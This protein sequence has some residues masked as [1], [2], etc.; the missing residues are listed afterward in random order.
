MGEEENIWVL[1]EKR[2]L[3][4]CSNQFNYF[5]RVFIYITV[6]VT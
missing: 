5:V 4:P 3:E 2:F 6:L 1:N